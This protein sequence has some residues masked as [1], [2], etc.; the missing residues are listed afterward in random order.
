M[1]NNGGQYTNKVGT[2]GRSLG[3]HHASLGPKQLFTSHH[4]H[5]NYA[6]MRDPNGAGMIGVE[7]R[8][9]M[10]NTSPGDTMGSGVRVRGPKGRGN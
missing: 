8:Q 2:T 1:S 6:P 3:R 7:T 4:Y 5:T 9:V 10:R